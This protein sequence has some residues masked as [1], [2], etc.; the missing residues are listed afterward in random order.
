[1]YSQPFS[2]AVIISFTASSRLPSLLSYTKG[3]ESLAS[4]L[5]YARFLENINGVIISEKCI[6]NGVSSKLA[7]VLTFPPFQG[8]DFTMYYFLVKRYFLWFVTLGCFRVNVSVLLS[9]SSSHHSWSYRIKTEAMLQCNEHNY[10]HIMQI[11]WPLA[12]RIVI[13]VYPRM[14][15]ARIT[16][17]HKNI[18][19]IF[20]LRF[21]RV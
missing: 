19:V 13:L 2:P 1:M 11:P 9:L 4:F 7:P 16:S 3:G 14:Q 17:L 12:A 5:C 15:W 21:S 18:Y 8:N 6:F 10:E 20:T